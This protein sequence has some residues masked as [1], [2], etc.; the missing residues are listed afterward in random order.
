MSVVRQF[1]SGINLKRSLWLS[2]CI[3]CWIYI[4]P[5]RL[6]LFYVGIYTLQFLYLQYIQY[7]VCTSRN[8]SWPNFSTVLCQKKCVVTFL[9]SLKLK[10]VIMFPSGCGWT[11]KYIHARARHGGNQKVEAEKEYLYL[12]QLLAEYI[13]IY[14]VYYIYI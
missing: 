2:I 3:F 10:I 12:E 13:S 9:R 5:H 7:M 4:C 14:T 1:R 8:I 11:T 6:Y